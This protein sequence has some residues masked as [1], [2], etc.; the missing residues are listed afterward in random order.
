MFQY[1][2]KRVLIFIPTLL[3]IS[4]VAFGLSKL[5]PGDPVELITKG[6]LGAGESGQA[7]D[8]L[9]TEQ[10]Y[11]ETA[12]RLGL[13]KPVFYCSFSPAAYPDTL[14]KIIKLADKENLNQLIGQYGNWPQISDYYK[15]IRHTEFAL[16]SIQGDSSNYVPR[17]KAR[18]SINSLYTN[19]KDAKITHLFKD[20]NAAIQADSSMLPLAKAHNKLTTAYENMQA[21]ATPSKNYIPS[22]KWY[23]ANNQYHTWITNFFGLNEKLTPDFGISYLDSRPVADK[24]W[25]ALRWTLTINIISILLAYLLSVPIGV[26]TA[27]KKDSVLDRVTTTVLFILYSLPTFWIGTLLIIFL[28]TPE[29]GLDFFPPGGVTDLP[30]TAPFFDRFLDIAH[31]FV[32][33]VACVTYGS[34]AFISRQMRGGMLTVIRQDYIR[35]ARAKGLADNK[36]IWKHAFRNSLFPIVTLFASIFPAAISG[37]VVIEV[38]YSIPG[39]GKL[40]ID[41]ILARDYPVVYTILMFAAILTML[42]NLVADMLYAV[43]D[44]RVSFKK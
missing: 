4:L 34:L 2:I 1:I 35:T 30:S 7:S 12:E 42:G 13:N 23:G 32:L 11:K 39:M 14:Y 9:A 15:A 44:P 8:M 24:M 19:Y 43:V 31:H 33:P 25:E 40:V 17:K 3:I 18:T 10:L 22:I 28:T 16:F 20:I 27:V 21:M 36:V 37:S 5:A 38:I 6:G 41:S 26:I 29:Y